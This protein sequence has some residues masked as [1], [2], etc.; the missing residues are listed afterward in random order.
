MS[1]PQSI[2]VADRLRQRR[3]MDVFPNCRNLASG[4][5]RWELSIGGVVV[6]V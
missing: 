5:F 4:V 6:E 3:R 1:P 2:G